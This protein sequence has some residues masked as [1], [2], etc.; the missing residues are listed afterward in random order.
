MAIMGPPSV[1]K[2]WNSAL[3]SL[4]F[5]DKMIDLY[6][7]TEDVAQFI[8]C[9]DFIILGSL[10]H[11]FPALKELRVHSNLFAYKDSFKSS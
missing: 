8:Q 3:G 2:I 1:L 11:Y 5:Q 6:C 7:Q 4:S 10:Q 9:Y